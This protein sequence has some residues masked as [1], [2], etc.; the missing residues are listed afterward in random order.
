[1]ELNIISH[2]SVTRTFIISPSVVLIFTS[3]FRASWWP[4]SWYIQPYIIHRPLQ[5]ITK[6]LSC[7]GTKIYIKKTLSCINFSFILLF[8]TIFY[9]GW[10]IVIFAVFLSW[11]LFKETSKS[12]TSFHLIYKRY[13]S[14]LKCS[15]YFSFTNN[16]T[17]ATA[18]AV[19]CDFMYIPHFPV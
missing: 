5:L 14:N 6:L 8:H 7:G 4:L 13:F 19:T 15:S 1:M 17:A 18:T 9:A 2:I 12:C 11:H 3:P 10:K 16:N